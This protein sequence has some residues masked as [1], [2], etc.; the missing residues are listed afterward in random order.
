MTSLL[1][2]F[3]CILLLTGGLTATAQTEK[4][5]AF[6]GAATSNQPFSTS[7]NHKLTRISLI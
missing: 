1:R 2:L 7:S 6:P 3:S 4:Q 5:I